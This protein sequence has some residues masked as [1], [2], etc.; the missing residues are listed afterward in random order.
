M[1]TQNSRKRCA[2]MP[3]LARLLFL[4]PMQHLGM[5]LVLLLGAALWA[6]L[7]A[8]LLLKESAAALVKL[9]PSLRLKGRLTL[10]K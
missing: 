3:L 4:P 2:M 8:V 6:A 1:K 10:L 7:V 9:L 5:G